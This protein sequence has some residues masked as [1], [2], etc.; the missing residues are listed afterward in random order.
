MNKKIM[1]FLILAII[2]IPVILLVFAK[3]K[4]S[5][6]KPVNPQSL[7]TQTFPQALYSEFKSS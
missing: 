1:M 6:D 5:T 4:S 7:K 3:N 2:A